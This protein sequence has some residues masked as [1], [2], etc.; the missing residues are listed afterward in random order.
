MDFRKYV[1]NQT[2]GNAHVVYIIML[3]PR[4]GFVHLELPDGTYA[5][6][7]YNQPKVEEE[8]DS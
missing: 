5:E 2:K 6:Q 7:I 3:G 4:E 8:I 1:E